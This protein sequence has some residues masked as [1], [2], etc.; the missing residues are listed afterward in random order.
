MPPTPTTLLF[1]GAYTWLQEPFLPTGDCVSARLVTAVF[2]ANAAGSASAQNLAAGQVPADAAAAGIGRSSS[3]MPDGNPRSGTA[4]VTFAS[5]DVHDNRTSCSLAILSRR[6][7][8]RRARPG[9]VLIGALSPL[10]QEIF[11]Y[12]E[13]P[14]ARHRI[15]G[16]ADAADHAGRGSL[17]TAGAV[18]RRTARRQ[19]TLLLSAVLTRTGWKGA[20]TGNWRQRL[21]RTARSTACSLRSTSPSLRHHGHR[22]HWQLHH[23]PAYLTSQRHRPL[24]IERPNPWSTPIHGS[25]FRFSTGHRRARTQSICCCFRARHPVD[26]RPRATIDGGSRRA[27]LRL[28]PVAGR[29]G[30]ADVE[31][32]SSRSTSARFS[33]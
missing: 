30:I 29:V 17:R 26:P 19:A 5:I 25:I 32:G 27:E 31:S 7:S 1:H 3:R 24:P 10:P 14:I 21:C 8:S 16:P 20:E 6:S 9:S 22:Q 28:E 13:G 11:R 15:P 23:Y 2:L 12:S 18:G 4:V 33:R